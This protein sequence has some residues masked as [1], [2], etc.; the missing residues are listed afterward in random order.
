MKRHCQILLFLIL[1]LSGSGVFVHATNSFIYLPTFRWDK[2]NNYSFA[3]SVPPV[4]YQEIPDPYRSLNTSLKVGRIEGIADVSSSGAAT[5]QIPI[6]VLDGTNQMQPQISVIY[7]SQS[8]NGLMGYA[9]NLSATSIITRV[10]KN[11]YYDGK[12]DELKFDTSDNLVLDGKRLM[13]TSGSNLAIGSVYAPEVEDY[14]VVEYMTINAR[15]AFRVKTKDGLVY[16]YGTNSDSYIRAQNNTNALYWLLS[17]VT[18]RYGNYM[19]YHYETNTNTGEFYLSSIEYTGNSTANISPYNRV[20][21]TYNTR[22][23]VI[24]S[25]VAGNII[26]Q[27]VLLSS[28]RCVNSGVAISEYKFKYIFDHYYSKLSEIEE[29]GLNGSKYN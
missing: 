19:L 24:D 10:G 12:A 2:A 4:V 16:E 22:D 14:S 6:K 15:D 21:F 26:S 13:L 9:W 27:K 18:D 17:K 8:D 25:Y 11:Y 28:I 5:Y 20:E 1:I 23:D 3:F 29:Y 7:N